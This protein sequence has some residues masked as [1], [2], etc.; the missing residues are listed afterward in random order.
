[1]K[2]VFK[3]GLVFGLMVGALGAKDCKE[4]YGKGYCVDYIQQKAGKKQSGNAKDWTSNIKKEDVKAGDV[5]IFKFGNWGHV[6]YVDKVNYSKD[7]KPE[8]LDISEWNWAEPLDSCARGPKFGITST[9]N[10]K[11]GKVNGGFWRP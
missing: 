7:N 11:L 5:A 2:R 6:A 9:R 3:I 4:Y 8:S 1:V 10:V